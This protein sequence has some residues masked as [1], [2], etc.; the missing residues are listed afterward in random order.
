MASRE[1]ARGRERLRP[2]AEVA[3]ALGIADQDL[4]PYG[5]WMA[6]VAPTPALPGAQA[7]GRLVLVT[8]VTPTAGGEGKTTVAI[9]LVDALRRLGERAVA[10]LRQPSLGPLFGAKGAG[11]GGGR[12][13]L[14]PA[15]AVNLHLTG[16]LHAV[17]AAHDLAAALLDNHLHHGNPLAI[18]PASVCWPRVLDVDDRALRETVVGL[19]PGNGPVR[20]VRW[21]ISAASEVMA[22]LALAADLPDLRRR[23]GRM[24]VGR[25]AGSGLATLEDLRAAGAMA[26]L[27]AEAVMPSLVQTLEGAPA[28][29]H[30]GPFGNVATGTSSV[31]AD[32]LALGLADY[33][34][35][36]A[37]FGT[38]L[39]AEKFFDI[40]CRQGGLVPAAAV[41]VA[42]VRTLARHGGGAGDDLAAVSRGA[43]N[44]RR[45]VANVR[46]FGVPV[47]VAVNAFAGDQAEALERVREAALE[48]GARAAEV[49]TPFADG[50]GGALRLAEAV[51]AAVREPG[52][53]QLLYPDAMPLA[54]KLDAIATAIYGADGV[55]PT[56]AAAAQLEE[57]EA[58][59]AGQ[60]PVC[61]AKTQH[62]LSHD[63][64]LGPHPRGY[65]LPVT[66]AL[67]AAGAGFVT[68]VCGDLSLMPGLPARPAAE[69]IDVDADGNVIGMR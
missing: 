50:A 30:A 65:R 63:A 39:G 45:H 57:I 64:R 48:A 22:A 12:A 25:R 36:E 42:T 56:R 33:V 49:A 43:E 7:R 62:S 5:R 27:L 21:I 23:L 61:M 19:G 44:L 69:D 24:I 15:D 55:D 68:A 59:G 6:K 32:R 34:V 11:T 18:E 47:V 4:F 41:L 37:G 31:I 58:A 13:Q 1:V 14:A 3:G 8:A 51:R 2:I 20:R 46:R 9:G 17:T 60:L 16:D 29:V 35:T 40:K 53:F 10:T 28:L 26:A 52:R 66:A 54:A 67:L 38:D